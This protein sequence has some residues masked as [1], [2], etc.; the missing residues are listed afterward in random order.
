MWRQRHLTF[1]EIDLDASGL[2]LAKAHHLLHV[3]QRADGN[4][5]LDDY[6]FKVCRSSYSCQSFKYSR[7]ACSP[8][9]F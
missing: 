4:R 6:S 5:V 1:A 9:L 2:N 7:P 8:T 3:P